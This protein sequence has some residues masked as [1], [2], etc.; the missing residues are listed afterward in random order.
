MSSRGCSVAEESENGGITEDR[1]VA[2]SL[3]TRKCAGYRNVGYRISLR[4]RADAEV[5]YGSYCGRS[6]PLTRNGGNNIRLSLARPPDL[7]H[8]G[9]FRSIINRIFPPLPNEDLWVILQ[10]VDGSAEFW[11][12]ESGVMTAYDPECVALLNI[13]WFY[14]VRDG[15]PLKAGGDLRGKAI[16]S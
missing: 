4:Q 9:L 12:M 2:S 7:H 6:R 3:P 16:I 5:Y 8:S 11:W 15:E 1:Q 14:S 10:A 13:A